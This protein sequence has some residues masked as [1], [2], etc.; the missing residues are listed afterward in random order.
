[1]DSPKK[2]GGRRPRKRHSPNTK[3]T[4][5]SAPSPPV[6]GVATADGHRSPCT[7]STVTPSGTRSRGVISGSRSHSTHLGYNYYSRSRQTPRSEDC[8]FPMCGQRSTILTLS[9]FS[10]LVTV[11][12][13]V[14]LVLSLYANT[15][16][17]I[18]KR[19]PRFVSPSVMGVYRD[20][21][22]VSSARQCNN[23]TR[24]IFIKNGTVGDAAVATMLCMCVVMPHRCGLGGGF[25]ATYYNRK[26]TNATAV[27]ATA[28]APAASSLGMFSSNINA[29]FA[30]VRAVATFGELKGYEL[31]LNVTGSRVPWR[32]L[33]EDAIT[34]AEGGVR[35]Y[36]DLARNIATVADDPDFSA[37][38]Y[39]QNPTTTC[40]LKSGDV[41]RNE[42]LAETLRQIADSPVRGRFLHSGPVMETTI[43]ELRSDGGI[44]TAE[45]FASFKVQATAAVSMG[46]SAHLRLFTTPPPTSGAILAFVMSIV[47]KIQRGGRLPDDISSAHYTVEALKFGFARRSHLGDPEAPEGRQVRGSLPVRGYR[48][49]VQQLHERLLFAVRTEWTRNAF[50][51]EQ[52]YPTRNAPLVIVLPNSD[53]RCERQRHFRHKCHGR[54]GDHL[55]HSSG[56]GTVPVDGSQREAKHRRRPPSQPAASRKRRLPREHHR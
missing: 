9:V 46:M 24:N 22:V 28:R 39:L 17:Y 43:K 1:M 47:D 52:L 2:G 34:L 16:H 53:C 8:H 3:S 12:I 18:P 36:D 7:F 40:V 4:T 15:V 30:G 29:S 21:V 13:L 27:L 19:Q 45:D 31:L 32:E 6:S 10:V 23:V 41:Y 42:K 37:R 11:A 20:W 33:F 5:P 49:V 44:L 26:T 48:S 50:Q 54:T 51:R 35:V 56:S 55:W 25:A 38:K 14:T